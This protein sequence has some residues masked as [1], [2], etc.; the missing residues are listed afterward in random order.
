MFEPG[1]L[2]LYKNGELEKRRS[3][4]YKILESCNLCPRNCKINRMKEEIGFCK[5]GSK[6]VISSYGAHFGEESPLVGELGSG[7]IFITN[8][9]LGCIFCQNYDI[10]HL[11][12]GHD[13][14]LEDLAVIMLS[15]QHR[16]CHNINFVSPTHVIPQILAAI[17]LAIEKGLTIP[18]VYN[19]GAYDSIHSIRLLDGVFDIYMPD[20]KFA[21]IEASKSYA[22]ATDYFEAA[23]TAILEMY[24]Q[25]GDLKLDSKNIAYR[26]L[27]IRHL[28]MPNNLAGT[29]K[30]MDFISSKISKNTY[31][32]I[33][34]QYRPC[35]EAHR[36]PELNRGIT[37]QEYKD[38]IDI[39]Y[40]YSL[41]RL[42]DRRRFPIHWLNF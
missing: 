37:D 18:L 42:D 28:V 3:L 10:S 30:V 9:N 39:A 31:I 35:G 6:P 8:C 24:R 5:T 41:T 22:Q 32:N 17:I 1:Y 40:K 25:V 20:F 16:G 38:A 13:I 12:Q 4:A 34:D 2:K 23:S 15:L 21:D 26:G 11:G 27:L 19:T 36:Y 33:M 29:E 14:S 7:T